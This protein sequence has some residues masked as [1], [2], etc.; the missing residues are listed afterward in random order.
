MRRGQRVQ[1]RK[2]RI[3]TKNKKPQNKQKKTEKQKN[4]K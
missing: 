4:L 2:S 1:K 3:W